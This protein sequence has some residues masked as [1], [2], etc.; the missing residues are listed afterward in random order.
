MGEPETSSVDP[1]TPF[2]L[3]KGGLAPG[4][5]GATPPFGSVRGSD[6]G[7]DGLRPAGIVFDCDGLLMDTEPCWTVAE[8]AV[9]AARGL[10][11]GPDEKARFIGKSVP[12][13]V[14]LMAAIFGEAGNEDAIEVEVL[15]TIEDV[16]S[17]EAQPMPGA[18][19]L[20]AAL[21]G[22][23]PIAV[24]SNSPRA[25]L[26]AALAR[27]DLAGAF[28]AVIAADEVVVPKPG[29]DLYLTACARLGVSA[30]ESLAFEDT[31]TG[32]AAARAAGMAVVGVPSLDPSGFPADIV[33]ASLA[34]P[35]V[36]AWA[37]SL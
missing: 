29:P 3:P 5:R 19:D 32:V 26:D 15:S 37:R 18:L 22:R 34:D 2:V 11:Y 1:A 21:Q 10:P 4:N 23:L 24:A 9:F 6:R 13:T 16:I 20:V 36:L 25:V 14:A 33:L 30:P 8:T 27:A 12:A 7:L 28:G 31:T 35:A 17:R